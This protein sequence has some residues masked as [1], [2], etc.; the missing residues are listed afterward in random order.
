M[1]D[2]VRL[3]QE[4]DK[5]PQAGF[6]MYLPVYRNQTAHDT[7][8]QRRASLVG[9]VYAPFRMNDLMQGIL[10]Q[11][12]GDMNATLDLEIHD[13]D[14][15]APGN[16]MFDSNPANDQSAKALRTTR[17]LTLFGHTWTVSVTALPAFEAGLESGN[18]WFV[19]AA[20]STAS[21]LL[22]LVL[23]LLANGRAQAVV[24]AEK[25]TRTL[26]LLS[27]CNMT[28][29][30]ATDE[31]KLLAEICRLVVEGGG[32]RMAWVGYAEHD[33]A[34]TVR[35]ITQFGYEAG[36]LDTVNITWADTQ[37]GQ[38]PTGTAIRTG[39][40]DVNQNYPDNPR[41]APWREAAIARGYRSSIALPL[42]NE[43]VTLGALTIYAADPEAFTPEEVHLLEEM[44]TDLAYGIVTLRT[45]AQ[46]AAAEE[47]VAFLAHY[48]ALTH[49]PNRLLLR[50]R[51]EHAIRISA[52]RK[53]VL[54]M[55]YLDL[56][57]F[58]QINDSLGHEIGDRLLVS[59]VERLRL[60]ISDTDT[61]S[62][63]SDDEFAV[64]LAGIPDADKAASVAN[65]IIEA[66]AEPLSIDDTPLS[67]SFSIGISLF[68]DDGRDFDTLL[69]N[70]G[71]AVNHAKESG[72]N[73][74]RFY[75][76]QM[77][78]DALDHLRLTGQLHNALKNRE[79]V[80][81]YQPQIDI[82]TGRIV[83]AEALVRW[84]HPIDGLVPPANFIP[85]AERSG[86]ILE[87]GEWVL[88]EACRQARLW[89]DSGLEPLVVAVNL[90]A[91]QFK[92]GDVMEM[93]STALA[94][95]GLPPASLELEL[96]ESI[97]LQD[98]EATLKTLRTLKA[99]G[100]RLSIDDFGTGY[101]SMSYLKRLAVNKIKIDQSFI[102]DL[103]VNTDDSAIVKAIIQLGHALQLVVIAE[104][105][106]TR[107]QL[108]FLTGYGCDE[109][110][111]YLYSKPVPAGQFTRLIER[112]APVPG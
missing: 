47:K 28:L 23:W 106:E 104:G 16:L 65:A 53:H 32:Y 42:I 70:A 95:S 48:D 98:V 103:T 41:M 56:D 34:R 49:L 55:L 3:L 24:M 110:Q 62:R 94:R 99:M 43:S 63:V 85:L 58:K 112:E 81:H 30:Y 21:V 26:R 91:L 75:T 64:L 25:M 15:P 111:G 40:T 100:V 8:D 57:N 77:N 31:Y 74:Y 73:T 72:R 87:I 14:R 51:F 11:Q 2:M 66:F 92:R 88:N 13:G 60:T 79:F 44:A 19:A 68:P 5:D 33:E 84:L 89:Q 108:E 93:V 45:R 97:L 76:L 18:S 90:S 39:V 9:W 35:P 86:H 109:V 52:H 59:A 67:I 96:T 102:R 10:A 46:H 7:V 101:S 36:Y 12:S 80:L 22:A 27:A 1:S 37:L 29:V 38:G 82:G 61:I 69:R 83:G 78:A 107:Q 54:A 17:T 105:V 4:T 20:G 71:S 6:L 50:D